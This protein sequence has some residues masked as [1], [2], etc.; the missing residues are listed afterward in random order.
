MNILLVDDH[1]M[2]VEFYHNFL[3]EYFVTENSITVSKALNCEQ[4]FNAI[5]DSN[6]VHPIDWAF[7]DY[8]LPAFDDQNLYSGSDVAQL[9]RKY[10]PN[11]KI[12][13]ITGHTGQA[14]QN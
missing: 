13:M 8:S 10:H 12:V 1:F 7:L 3:S 11:C 2:A 14:I 9:V 5:I 4:A 6:T